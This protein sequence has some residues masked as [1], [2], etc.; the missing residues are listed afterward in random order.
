L[1]SPQDALAQL[2]QRT[3]VRD[4]TGPSRVYRDAAG[5]VY[6]SVTSILSATQDKSGLENWAAGMERMYGT[7]AATQ[8]RNVAAQRGTQ[9]HNQAEYLLKTANKLSRNT[10]NRTG[11]FKAGA[12][13][14]YR[15]PATL[16]QW[17]L[18]KASSKLPP[19]GWSSAGY[20]RSLTSWITANV[21]QCFACEFAVS[22]PYG[23]LDPLTKTVR[24]FNALERQTPQPH[25]CGF[26]GTSDGLVSVGSETLL[27][28]GGNP[29]LAGAP[30]I[31]DWKTSAKRKTPAGLENYRLQAGAYA[32]GLEHLTGIQP[33]GAFIVLARRVGPPDTAFLTRDELVLA[34]YQYLERCR[35]FYET[36]ELAA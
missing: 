11:A 25:S 1:N 21:T 19:C 14:L 3:L 33:A 35:Q 27:R 32:L 6:H 23:A 12:D 2:H 26:A 31:A 34:Q 16:Y 7:G 28:H 8:E 9:T 5:A 36:L 13:G 10:A 22:Y 17:A 29:D 4:D 20:A 15:T 24:P 18:A 30:F